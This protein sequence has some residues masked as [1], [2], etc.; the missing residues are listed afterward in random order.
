MLQDS[1]ED[2]SQS[3]DL[4]IDTVAWLGAS[5]VLISSRILY[6]SKNEVRHPWLDRRPLVAV[7]GA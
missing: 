1:Y 5:A 3:V 6:D 2:T 7:E 4:A